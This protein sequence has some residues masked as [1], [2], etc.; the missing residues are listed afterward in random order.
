[1]CKIVVPYLQLGEFR[2]ETPVGL[3]ELLEPAWGKRT[4]EYDEIEKFASQFHRE[5]FR[6]E[7][8]RIVTE[9]TKKK[10]AD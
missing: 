6:N 1:M 9:Y 8:G 3:S 5:V 10:A 4:E 2:V 7:E